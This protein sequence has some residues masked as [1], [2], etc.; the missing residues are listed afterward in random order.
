MEHSAHNQN[1]NQH[2]LTQEMDAPIAEPAEPTGEFLQRVGKMPLFSG[3][4]RAYEMGK[5]TS[6]VVRYGADLVESSVTSISGRVASKVGPERIAQ[7]DRYA[8]AALDRLGQFS[9]SQSPTSLYHHQHPQHECCPECDPAQASREI[10]RRANQEDHAGKLNQG[11][12]DNHYN[13]PSLITSH[14]PQ[15]PSQ[16]DHPHHHPH[17]LTSFHHETPAEDESYEEPNTPAA[18]P[19]GRLIEVPRNSKSRWQNMLVEAGVT[20]GG[21]GAA[22]SEESMKSLQ[23]CLQWLHYATVHLDHQITVLRDFIG[24][25]AVAH[26]HE[27]STVL[28]SA[29]AVRNLARIKREVV[30]TIRKVVDVVSKYAGRLL[31]GPQAAC[32]SWT[33][34]A[35]SSTTTTTSSRHAQTKAATERAADRILTFAVESLDMLKSIT[36][37]FSESV[38]RADAWVERLRLIGIQHRNRRASDSTQPQA[39]V[40]GGE[41]TGGAERTQEGGIRGVQ[42]VGS[43]GRSSGAAEWTEAGHHHYQHHHHHHQH[44]GLV[45]SRSASMS[46]AGDATSMSESLVSGYE[47][48][49]AGSLATT[50]STTLTLGSASSHLLVAE[51]PPPPPQQQ[52]QSQPGPDRAS[53]KRR[54]AN[55]NPSQPAPPC[56]PSSLTPACPPPTSSL[57]KLLLDHDQVSAFDLVH[58]WASD[59]SLHPV[60]HHH[61]HHHHHHPLPPASPA[62]QTAASPALP[63]HRS[64]SSWLSA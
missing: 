16:F 47:R 3:V 10:R 53:A 23:Y 33:T 62:P 17:Y 36:A 48:S 50:S 27:P 28:I 19:G 54:K 58:R 44:G 20:A 15:E 64:E 60:D 63:D 2:T 6:K 45:R 51:A 25:L 24:S 55:N 37:I 22:V 40:A 42:G 4:V 32:S 35:P 11:P 31:A 41:Q 29:R 59:D 5:G 56:R 43:R 21:I 18:S 61:H 38:E 34:T 49:T 46:T 7:I 52:Q 12:Q 26:H 8:G 39:V 14:H 9:R 13:D 1:Q 57:H 30:E